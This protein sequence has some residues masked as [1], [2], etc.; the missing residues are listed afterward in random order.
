MNQ[1][2]FAKLHGV[3]RKTVTTW[4]ARGWLVLAGDDIDVEASNANIERF[5]KTVTRSEKKPA[6][7]KQGNKTGNRS[8]GNKSGNK[9]DKDLAESPTKT[10]ERMIAEHGVTMTLDEA[11]QMKENFLA[12]LTQLEYDIK[13]GQ[14]LPYKDMIEAVGN[15]YARMRTRLIA[16][17][18]EHGPRLRVLA[19]T[20]NDAEFV[21]AL[22]EVV[23]EAMEELSLDADNNRG[24]N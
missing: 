18:P 10:V 8:S 5:R 9:N 21:Q 4:K 12:L 20:T 23:Y 7:N 3:S 1:S 15:E 17:A 13:S 6:G 11:R 2:D 24:E 16:I 14:V 22:Q 19:S